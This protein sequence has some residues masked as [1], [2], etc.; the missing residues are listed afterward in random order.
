MTY[1]E[2][3]VL[4]LMMAA[5]LAAL[6]RRWWLAAFCAGAAALARPEGLFLFLPLAAIAWRQ[7]Q[8]LSPA[9]SWRRARRRRG[10][11]G[12]DCLLLAVSRHR[13]ARPAR[14]ERGRAGLGAP[15]P[16]QRRIRR[17]RAS[18][19][20]A[21]TR[22]V[23][24]ARRRL[25]LPL[26]RAPVRGAAGRDA[27]RLARRRRR[28]RDPA[29]LHGS[30]RLDRPLRPARAAALLG[31]RRTHKERGLRAPRPL[32][33]TRPARRSAPHLSRTCSHRDDRC[34]LPSSAYRPTT[35][36]RTSSR[37]CARSASAPRASRVLVIDD[38]SPDG[39]GELADRL[40]ARAR[41]RRRPPPRRAR[42]ASG[43]RTSTG[44]GERSPAAPSS[45]S[46]WTATS[47]TTRPTCRG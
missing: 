26:P 21:R 40:A 18:A 4:V 7:R 46:R 33:V 3:V 42:R 24:R 23:A 17:I 34:R 47:R 12:S 5:P 39:T 11:G 38:N 27:S 15:I 30:L 37:W 31:P 6:R 13:S 45:C 32:P 43:G 44:S 9:Q 1:P 14:L 25:L 29:R 20:D 41:R 36:A 8:S 28:C 16:D 10:A 22:P 19:R 35:S 2:S